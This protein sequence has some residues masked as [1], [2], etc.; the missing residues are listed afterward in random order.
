MANIFD[1]LNQQRQGGRVNLIEAE[2]N[3]KT[4]QRKL[5][6]WKGQTDNN[7]FTNFPLLHYC[8]NKIKDI[9]E[10]EELKQLPRI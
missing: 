4:F 8:V 1:A 6:L 2:E 3:L 10:P 9:S 7:N 5:F